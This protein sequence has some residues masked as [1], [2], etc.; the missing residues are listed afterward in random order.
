MHPILADPIVLG[1][2]PSSVSL[3]HILYQELGVTRWQ[4]EALQTKIIASLF[5]LLQR[6]PLTPAFLQWLNRLP[7]ET[8]PEMDWK[9]RSDERALSLTY[10]LKS[11]GGDLRNELIRTKLLNPNEG[12]VFNYEV[13][14]FYPTYLILRRK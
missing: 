2:P 12:W 8:F 6:D 14:Q 7:K 5:S 4:Y 11:F 1:I 3:R 9:H 10:A 13:L